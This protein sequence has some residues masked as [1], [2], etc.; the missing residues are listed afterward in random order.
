M[1][2]SEDARQDCERF[3][4]ASRGRTAVVRFAVPVDAEIDPM[5]GRAVAHEHGLPERFFFLPN[6]FWQHKDHE[7]VIR[8][9]ALLKQCG[10]RV[11]VA[12]SGRQVDLR[13]PGH[14]LR[15]QA[16]IDAL[17]VRDEFRLLGLIPHED[18]ALLMRICTGLINPSRFEGWS[19]T[20]EEAKAMG[21]P[22]LLSRLP[23]HVEQAGSDAQYFEPGSAEEL[24]ARLAEFPVLDDEARRVRALDGAS[25][26]RE[27]VRLYVEDFVALAHRAVNGQ[28]SSRRVVAEGVEP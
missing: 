27:A 1:L 21:T 24:A 9:L 5:R 8:A 12:A 23:V 25:R 11:V 17:G 3:Y 13:D 6:Q 26:N 10:Q 28:V 2:S 4:R 20:V 18:V 22:M 16:L 15:L 14:V 19:T 7:C